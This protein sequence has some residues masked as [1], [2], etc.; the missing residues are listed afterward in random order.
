M[1]TDGHGDGL[2]QSNGVHRVMT[3]HM[4]VWCVCAVCVCSFVFSF[5]LQYTWH[6]IR[7]HARDVSVGKRCQRKGS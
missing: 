5:K 4:C 6:S 7:E 2:L 1:R 3:M